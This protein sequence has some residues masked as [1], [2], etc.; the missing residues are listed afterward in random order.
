MSLGR[1]IEAISHSKFWKDTCIFVVEDD[2]QMGF[3]HIDGHRTVAFVISPYT[4]RK[5]VDSTN[6]NQTSMVRTIELILGLPPMNQIDASAT[7]MNSCFMEKADLTPY[8]AVP[9]LIPLD[10][11]NPAD[12]GDQGSPRAALGGAIGED[13][14]G[15]SRQGG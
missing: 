14:S 15:R 11:L 1:I 5:V 9:N 7:P 12:V 8:S 2:P 4:R 6:Y 13:E 10:R 3:D